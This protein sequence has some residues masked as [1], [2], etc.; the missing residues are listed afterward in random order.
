M[1]DEE[2]NGEQLLSELQLLREELSSLRTSGAERTRE[3][4]ATNEQLKR[5]IVDRESVEEALRSSEAMLKSILSMSPAGIGLTE[6]RIVKWANEAWMKMFGFENR[7]EYEGKDARILYPSEKDYAHVGELHRESLTTGDVAAADVSFMRKDGS[8]FDGHIKIKAFGSSDFVRGTVSSISDISERKRT[9][10]S[11]RQSEERYRALAENSLTGICLHRDGRF[12]YANERLA[13]TLGYETDE[14]IGA[15]WLDLVW[16]ED[17]ELVS[18]RA[19]G[20]IAGQDVPSQ[21]VLRAMTKTG[22]LRYVEAWATVIQHDGAPAILV[23]ALDITE[24]KKVEEALRRSEEKYRLLV[25]NAAIGILSITKEGQI[26]DLNKQVLDILGSPSAEATRAINILTFPPLV[27]AGISGLLERCLQTGQQISCEV[28]YSS[29]WGKSLYLRTILT[30]MRDAGGAINGC[31]AALEDVTARK[32]AEFSLA[33]S[34]RKLR[35]IVEHS[36]NLFY[37]HTPD[38]ELTYVSP[39]TRQFF[40]CEPEEA[41]VHWTDFLTDNPRNA[42][43]LKLT[44]RAVRTGEIQPPYELE[45]IGKKGRKIWVLVNESPVVVDG[46]TVAIVGSLTDITR[47]KRSELAQRRLATAVEQTA[48]AVVITDPEGHIE[49]VNPAFER[50]TGYT[51]E[52]VIGDKSSLFRSRESDPNFY[53]QSKKTLPSGEIW[54]SRL[55]EKR[56]DGTT[57]HEDVT[58]S[59]VRDGSGRIANYVAIKRDVSQEVALQQQLL[60]A[61]KMEAIGTLAGGIAHDFNNLL[62][63]TLGYSEMLLMDKGESDPE[64]S[65]L[66]KIVQAAR[67]GADL[68]QGL[69]TFSRKVEPRPRPVDLNQRIRRIAKL[70]G[71]TLPRMIHIELVLAR[72]LNTVDADPTQ[73]EQIVMNLA[74]NARDAMPEGGRLKIRT[75]NICLDEEFCRVHPEAHAGNHVMLEI[76]D[77]GHGMDKE[78]LQHIFEPFY[79]T[80]EVGRGTGLGLATV[81][82]IVKQHGGYVTCESESGQGTCF[83]IYLPVVGVSEEQD[84]KQ[85]GHRVSFGTETILLVDDE[86]FVR[87]LGERMLSKAGYTVLTAEDGKMAVETYRRNKDQISLV[88]LDLIMPEMGG[89]QCLDELAKINPQLKVLVASGYSP[90]ALGEASVDS[91]AKGF[92]SKPFT[93][94]DLL[95]DVRKV[96]DSD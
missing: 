6:D 54:S 53:E 10:E 7:Q 46:K 33:E 95:R 38:H 25:E 11:L 4:I 82:G 23:N 78:T 21:Y 29:K 80:K 69:L 73:V 41:L 45:L 62:Q 36:T 66:D 87:E 85:V 71:R 57:Y 43:G 72:D 42:T 50:I 65:D 47:R 56:K 68:V 48:E 81:Y 83:K 22:E 12:L 13:K 19:R 96:L 26:T 64:R 3:L 93:S 34:E 16:P 84:E 14:L 76:S 90:E 67:R 2:K 58:I 92:V 30:P 1:K 49:Y 39:Q 27:Q 18:E 61:Q 88:I 9:E 75:E 32:E 89:K 51:R 63:V 17:R 40:D 24:R 77:T 28:P 20:R 70:L 91:W 94:E 44:E 74:V 59:P 52:E 15:S 5:E 8:L 55:V 60:Q 31:Q 35:A 37:S 79:T 86:Q